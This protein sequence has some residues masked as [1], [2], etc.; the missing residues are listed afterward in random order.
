MARSSRIGKW[1]IPLNALYLIGMALSVIYIFNWRP[2][3]FSMVQSSYLYY[4][5]VVFFAP[6]FLIYP[7]TPEGRDK[8]VPW[9]DVALFF[10]ALG[11][12]LYFGLTAIRA[13]TEGW[14]YSAPPLQTNLS[15]VLWIM[16][17]EAIRRVSGIPLTTVCFLFSLFPLVADKMPGFLNGVP[18]TFLE[19]ARAHILGLEGVFGIPLRTVG[20][21]LVGFIIFG[22][23]LEVSGA[24]DFL[25]RISS[26]F[27]SRTAGGSAKIAIV[28]S[29]LFGS[30]SG[31]VLSNIAT[32]GTFA[33]PE[34]KKSGYDKEYAGAVECVAATGG[35][36]MPP[37]MG[38]AAFIMASFLRMP[39]IEICI[40]AFLPSLLYYLTLFIQADSYAKANNLQ[41]PSGEEIPGKWETFKDGWYYIL[42]FVTLVYF[43]AYMKME[44]NAPYYA[45]VVLFL[46]AATKKKTRLNRELALKFIA[47]SGK[48][49]VELTVIL[50]AIGLIIGG[51]TMTGVSQAF[52]RELVS[53][54]GN[55]SF[56]LLLACAVTSGILGM[57]MTVTACYTFLAVTVAPALIRVGINPV[58]AHLFVMYWGLISYITPPVA[59][60]AITAAGIAGG[61]AIK[62]GFKSMKLGISTYIVPFVFA[63]NP[64]LI[65]QGSA[66]ET[67]LAFAT[68]CIG[69]VAIS[70]A[71]EGYLPGIGRIKAVPQGIW[72]M[73]GAVL[74][75][76]QPLYLR[77]AGVALLIAFYGIRFV[78]GARRRANG[79]SQD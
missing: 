62:T 74:T 7:A 19:T 44:S 38:A 27:L 72:I 51:L 32:I 39:Y 11:I 20:T 3:G 66:V 6:A 78:F 33:I 36:L 46:V 50:A 60:G 13:I 22:A 64:A 70:Y 77:L 53:M 14:E 55:N 73:A 57:G 40:A 52:S 37:V 29:G 79:I 76:F 21:Q 9:Y 41:A 56:L 26:A 54:V 25:L 35:S 2:F 12:S 67:A 68:T 1:Q 71:L 5:L 18:F 75:L 65:F 49:L 42:A 31:S 69:M 45:T 34:M 24:S 43:M 8:P 15:I 58:A 47:T 16:V 10:I 30:L 17:V 4:L 63:Y 48:L 28:S 23:A 61:D 59:L